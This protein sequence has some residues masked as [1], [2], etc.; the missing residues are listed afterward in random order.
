MI[1]NILLIESAK[2]LIEDYVKRLAGRYELVIVQ[3]FEDFEEKFSSNTFAAI[4]I[5]PCLNNFRPNTHDLAKKIRYEIEFR[6]PIIA[7][8]G[9]PEYCDEMI[10]AGCTHWCDTFSL[11][12]KLHELLGS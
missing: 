9:L 4:A 8:T 10:D 5:S 7:N 1:K 12:D 11:P 6:G 2:N 3:R